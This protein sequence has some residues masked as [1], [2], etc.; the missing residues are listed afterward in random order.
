MRLHAL[1]VAGFGPFPEPVDVDFDAVC[2]AGLFLIHGATGAGKTS[3]LD[4]VCFAIFADVPGSRSRRGLVS[5][6][7]PQGTRPVVTLEFTSGGRRFRI[8]RSPEYS[9]PKR[10]GSGTTRVPASVVLEEW[11]GTGWRPV[12]TRHDEVADLLDQVLGMGLAQFA[13]VVVLPQGDVSAFLRAS[14]EDRRALLERLFDISAYTD[15]EEWLVQERR[16]TAAAADEIAAAVDRDRDR[17]H[18]HVLNAEEPWR[19]ACADRLPEMLR[20]YVSELER[21]VGDLLT[22]A[23]A[24]T[25]TLTASARAA[26]EGRTLAA[27]LE[28]GERARERRTAELARRSVIGELRHRVAR[29][30]AAD[31]VAGHLDGLEHAIRDEDSHRAALETAAAGVGR[32]PE[33]VDEELVVELMAG[34]RAGDLVVSELTH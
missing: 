2:A 13:K 4:A 30:V 6:H 18:D 31:G 19:S 10:R 34:V 7:A 21:E 20:A 1:R 17:L 28:R 24:A 12:S 29:A 25:A 5:D 26:Q 32:T 3:L 8:E 27:D 16:R 23:D 33:T 14:P 9:R 15:V 22:D 11:S